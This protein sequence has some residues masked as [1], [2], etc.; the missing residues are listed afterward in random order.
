[1]V[2]AFKK[3]EVLIVILSDSWVNTGE[4][5]QPLKTVV[6]FYVLRKSLVFKNSFY[7]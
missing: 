2:R 5:E 7:K 4:E 1:M 6:A 3:L